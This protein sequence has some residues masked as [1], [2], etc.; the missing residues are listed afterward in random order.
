MIARETEY[1]VRRLRYEDAPRAAERERPIRAAEPERVAERRARR[2]VAGRGRGAVRRTGP[3]CR[4]LS[5]GV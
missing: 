4:P 3:A 5:A 2:G 1:P